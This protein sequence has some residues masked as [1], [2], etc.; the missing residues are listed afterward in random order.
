MFEIDYLD[1]DFAVLAVHSEDTHG[2]AVAG[3]LKGDGLVVILLG[4]IRKDYF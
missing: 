1:E 2:F 4:A 3:E